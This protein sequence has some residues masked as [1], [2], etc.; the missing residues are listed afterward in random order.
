MA[1]RKGREQVS[2]GACAMAASL[3]ALEDHGGWGPRRGPRKPSRKMRKYRKKKK[4]RKHLSQNVKAGR[5]LFQQFPIRFPAQ[6]L[7][8]PPSP[9]TTLGKDPVFK[10]YTGRTVWL[11]REW[12][13]PGLSPWNSSELHSYKEYRLET[14]PLVWPSAFYKGG[15]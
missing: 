15:D 5:T 13:G 7:I 14:T 10:R 1:L 12:E 8:L 3:A 6:K 4:K 2:K 9:N 11:E